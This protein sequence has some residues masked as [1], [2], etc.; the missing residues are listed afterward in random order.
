MYVGTI[1]LY[2][3]FFCVG[4][5]DFAVNFL[6]SVPVDC[7]EMTCKALSRHA[8]CCRQQV[9]CLDGMSN[10]STQQ[11]ACLSNKKSH[12][13]TSCAMLNMFNFEQLVAQTLQLA[14]TGNKLH[15]NK[16]HV[17]TGLNVSS[18]TLKPYSLTP[19][20]IESL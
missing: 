15:G 5:I 6:L 12:L 9:A 7:L 19:H 13:A 3:G 10:L 20:K 16:L 14:Q 8:T 17:W 1:L 4:L 18:G 11:V 2:F